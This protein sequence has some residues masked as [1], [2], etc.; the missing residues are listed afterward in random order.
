MCLTR[1]VRVV[2]VDGA[3]AVVAIGTMQRRASTL[4]V[5]E[6]QAG[7]W[8]ILTAGIL[9]HVLDEQTAQQMLAALDAATGIQTPGMEETDDAPAS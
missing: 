5:P 4:A 2:A 9:V 7:D 1:P 8:A 6:V 3:S